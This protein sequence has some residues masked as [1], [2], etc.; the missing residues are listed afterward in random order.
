MNVSPVPRLS[1]VLSPVDLQINPLKTIVSPV[2]HVS[3]VFFTR[4]RVRA[5][6]Y[7]L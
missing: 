2:S 3:P 5:R 1:P 4:I 6:I 7:F